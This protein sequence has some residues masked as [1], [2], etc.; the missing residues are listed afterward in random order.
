MDIKI[1]W[2]FNSNEEIKQKKEIIKNQ[3][4]SNFK[5]IGVL[6]VILIFTIQNHFTIS[7]ENKTENL[8]DSILPSIFFIL[9]QI[10]IF[11]KSYKAQVEFVTKKC[12]YMKDVP[13]RIEITKDW[14]MYHDLQQEIKYSWVAFSHYKLF[15]DFVL[16]SMKYGKT[17]DLS[18]KIPLKNLER[19]E[20]DELLNTI[21]TKYEES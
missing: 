12:N 16:I 21:R 4:K 6:I 8:I 13:V 20:K 7:H 14:I 17:N 19:N 18:V 9:L 15:K 10:L 1:E 11:Y 3:F 5:W 2:T